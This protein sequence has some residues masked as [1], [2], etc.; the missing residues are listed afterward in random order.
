MK[1][2]KTGAAIVS[3]L[4]VILGALFASGA[5]RPTEAIHEKQDAEP[6][7]LAAVIAVPV[8]QTPEP[9]QTPEP[10]SEPVPAPTPE[11]APEPTPELPE[12]TE[13]PEPEIDEARLE[14]LA[15][16]IYQE[17]G[18]N[19]CSD[20]SR[21]RAGDVVLTRELD[22]R[23]PDTLEEVLTQKG[24]FGEYYWTG[25]KWPARAS[26]PEEA[27][28]VQ[29]AYDTARELLSGEHSDL[30]GLGY[31]WLAEFPQG[32]DVIYADGIYFGR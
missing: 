7:Q 20:L 2:R 19:A 21:Y 31:I 27:A 8:I 13:E 30:W 29:R 17:A 5:V 11:P 26:A 6:A 3:V 25:I 14:M 9:K 18:G 28:A 12:E 1:R 32:T 4:I 22:S 16:V 23:F 15:C 24:Q 10:M